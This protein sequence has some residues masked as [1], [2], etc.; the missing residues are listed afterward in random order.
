[1]DP[2][3]A[4]WVLAE[5]IAPRING[6]WWP[7]AR[8]GCAGRLWCGMCAADMHEQCWGRVDQDETAL[9]GSGRLR[10]ERPRARVWLADRVCGYPCPCTVCTPPQG[11]LF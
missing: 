3:A 11:A 7:R 4:A 9:L 6:M 2:A 10:G 1:M 8:C 5:V